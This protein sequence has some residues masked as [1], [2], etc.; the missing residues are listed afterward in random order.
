MRNIYLSGAQELEQGVKPRSMVGGRNQDLAATLGLVDWFDAY[1]VRLNPQR[2]QGHAFDINETMGD[3]QASVSVKR[4]TEFTR[5]HY[6]APQ[7]IAEFHIEQGL[8]E[9]IASGQ[10]TLDQ[11]LSQGAVIDGNR[12]AVQQWLD[13][14]DVFNFWFN[15]VTP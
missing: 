8:L 5:I 2:S 7:P 9:A 15:I 10:L 12:E 14:H 11:A 13:M 1:A 6:H 4:Q 3:V